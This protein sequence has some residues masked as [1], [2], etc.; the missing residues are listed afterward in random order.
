[1][2]HES[3][4]CLMWKLEWF[5]LG[6]N[7]WFGSGCSVVSGMTLFEKTLRPPN[8]QPKHTPHEL[9]LKNTLHSIC[10]KMDWDLYDRILHNDGRDK[11]L[12]S[13]IML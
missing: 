2:K 6:T 4:Y 13:S 3:I 9:F 10:G 7:Y 8:T 11:N 5:S 12:Y 1:M